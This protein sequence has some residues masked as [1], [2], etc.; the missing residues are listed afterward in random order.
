MSARDQIQPASFKMADGD[1]KRRKLSLKRSKQSSNG[2]VSEI[3]PNEEKTRDD[4]NNM[5]IGL[6]N[7]GNTC[8]INAVIQVLRYCPGVVEQ[9]SIIK[10]CHYH[11]TIITLVFPQNETPTNTNNQIAKEFNEVSKQQYH[12]INH[13][14]IFS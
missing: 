9:L 13:M 1:V 8:Y 12:M 6:I 11:V 5:Y 2:N 10:V 14:I 3:K 4:S 7:L